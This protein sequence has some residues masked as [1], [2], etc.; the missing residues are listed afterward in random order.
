MLSCHILT[1]APV[2]VSHRWRGGEERRKGKRGGEGDGK[3]EGR[4]GEGRREGRGEEV[5]EGV[6]LVC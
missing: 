5:G 3:G 2:I 1:R 4:R 6:E